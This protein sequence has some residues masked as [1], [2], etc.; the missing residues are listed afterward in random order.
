MARMQHPNILQV[1]DFDQREINGI[2]TG[3]PYPV[4]EDFGSISEISASCH[5]Y[6][7]KL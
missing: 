6:R 2:K 3:D 7:K 5:G 4:V 1:F